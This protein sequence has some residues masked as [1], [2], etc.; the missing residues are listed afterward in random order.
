MSNKSPDGQPPLSSLTDAELEQVE[1]A[2]EASHEAL[3]CAKREHHKSWQKIVGHLKELNDRRSRRA[4]ETH[5]FTG[6]KE[7]TGYGCW[8]ETCTRCGLNAM[9]VHTST[10]P[11][12]GGNP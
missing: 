8:V 5:D 10:V 11:C 1:R 12:D 6:P 4:M 3:E 2:F 7:Q 9:L